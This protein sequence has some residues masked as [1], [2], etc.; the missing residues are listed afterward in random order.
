MAMTVI[1]ERLSATPPP[2]VTVFAVEERVE[3]FVDRTPPSTSLAGFHPC[4][5][6][7]LT[8]TP[9]FAGVGAE[10]VI[11]SAGADTSMRAPSPPDPAE[12]TTDPAALKDSLTASSNVP[13]DAGSEVTANGA[14]AVEA[15]AV[16][17]LVPVK[18]V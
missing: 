12:P 17:T 14:P 3:P 9:A 5:T 2:I 7:L 10:P 11:T 15:A 18:V 13:A 4:N 1:S 16:N 8:S 6:V